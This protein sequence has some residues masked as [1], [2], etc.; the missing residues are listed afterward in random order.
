MRPNY[1]QNALIK[2]VYDGD[3]IIADID[4]GKGIWTR[5]EV[6]RFYGI[7]CNEI[8]RSKRHGRGDEH[9]EI[10]FDQRDYL[11]TELGRSSMNYPR[12]VKY[13]NIS[14]KVLVGLDLDG[15]GEPD[16]FDYREYPQPVPV[17][18]QTILDKEKFGRL[19]GVV[20]RGDVNI[21]EKLRD[22]IG[23]VE[24]YDGKTYPADYPIKAPWA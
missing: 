2:A 11:L 18:I 3:T 8:K 22:I 4:W 14:E 19:L 5:D 6:V 7:N 24:F 15:D 16:I 1:T 12:K 20:W 10:G 13:H 21:N 23:G 17:V 9:V